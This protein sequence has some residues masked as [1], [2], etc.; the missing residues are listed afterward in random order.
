MNAWSIDTSLSEKRQFDNGA[1]VR[2]RAYCPEGSTSLSVDRTCRHATGP[3]LCRGGFDN[4]VV[5]SSLFILGSVCLGN[6]LHDLDGNLLEM[7]SG[8]PHCL[9]LFRHAVTVPEIGRASCRER[10]W[11]VVR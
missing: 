2:C 8:L 5:S 4:H 3:T 1:R 6:L 10:G 11:S 7:S 9:A